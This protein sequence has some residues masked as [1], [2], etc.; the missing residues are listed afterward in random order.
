MPAKP[1]I[2]ILA[3]VKNAANEDTYVPALVKASYQLRV[4]WRPEDRPER[5]GGVTIT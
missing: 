1:I 4:Q 3:V 5:R 2:N